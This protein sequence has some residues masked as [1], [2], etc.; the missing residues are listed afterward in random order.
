MTFFLTMLFSFLEAPPLG[1]LAEAFGGWASLLFPLVAKF[2]LSA[3]VL[4]F[5]A[6]WLE[7]FLV[8]WI[9]QT[10]DSRFWLVW[11]RLMQSLDAV[12]LQE[13]CDDV[14]ASAGEPL[15]HRYVFHI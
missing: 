1:D 6:V 14:R 12:T 13:L 9:K 15:D 7:G 11:A 2:V 10:P 3:S 8:I 5:G 4:R